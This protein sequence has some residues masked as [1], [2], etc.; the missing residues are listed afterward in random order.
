ME[1]TNVN[2][3]EV[4]NL[5]NRL[6]IFRSA[7]KKD[8]SD[9]YAGELEDLQEKTDGTLQTIYSAIDTFDKKAGEPNGIL[10]GANYISSIYGFA[11]SLDGEFLG[12]FHFS[13]NI[14]KKGKSA[15]KMLDKNNIYN[16]IK[17]QILKNIK[18]YQS[19]LFLKDLTCITE[20]KVKYSIDVD[21][22]PA[23]SIIVWTKDYICTYIT[24]DEQWV[25]TPKKPVNYLTDAYAIDS[26]ENPKLD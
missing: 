9:Y 10:F 18:S 8:S 17:K 6:N 15:L 3:E 19:D 12:G 16:E 2:N 24:E 23:P 13:I 21:L 26:I 14:F 5:F 11:G 20:D 1:N 7:T 25:Y 22:M 4:K